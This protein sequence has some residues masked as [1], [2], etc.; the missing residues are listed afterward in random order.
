LKRLLFVG[1]AAAAVAAGAFAIPNVAS[2][3][4]A[5]TWKVTVT[6]LTGGQ[7][8]SPPLFAVH[9]EDVRVWH[10][11]TIA[12][13]VVAGI[14]EDA[15]NAPA[16]EALPQVEGVHDVF[17]GEGGPIPPGESRTYHVTTQDQFDRLSVGS[18]LVNTNDGFTGLDAVRLEG[19]GAEV[20]DIAWDAGSESNN[21]LTGFIPGPCCENQFVRDPNGKLISPHEGITGRGELDPAEFGW[22]GEV[23]KF[24]IE[25]SR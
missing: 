14:A 3:S 2:A 12:S 21:E 22:T 15:D 10:P 16:E 24:R 25:R 11:G 23:A 18:L 7:P 4:Q 20:R 8:M 19:E 1:L 6:N 17:T 5:T 13:H 9:N